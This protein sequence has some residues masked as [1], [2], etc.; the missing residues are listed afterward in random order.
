MCLQSGSDQARE[1][2]GLG[3]DKETRWKDPRLLNDLVEPKSLPTWN[4]HHRLLR[5]KETHFCLLGATK[6]LLDLFII[7]VFCYPK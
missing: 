2:T 6:S 3:D 4:E 1:A 5:V 7:G